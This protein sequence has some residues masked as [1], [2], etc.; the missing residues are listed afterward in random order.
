MRTTLLRFM[1]AF[2]GCLAA[3]ILSWAALG[4]GRAATAAPAAPAAVAATITQ[5]V[6]LFPT[7]DNT[8]YE[9]TLGKVS[10]GAGQ[11]LFAGKTDTGAI[12]RGLLAF[13]LSVIPPGATVLSATLTLTMS[14]TIGGESVV[15][16]H[17]V[18]AGWGEGASD[19]A[20]E[21]GAGATAEVGDAT[22]LHT[23]YDTDLWGQPGGDFEPVPSAATAVEGPGV[24]H[25]A[26]PGLSADVASWLAGPATHHGW[27]LLG[28]ETADRT[29]KRFDSREND[30]ANRPRLTITYSAVVERVLVPV[31]V[32]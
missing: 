3:L 28:D 8:L 16:L 5:T 18:T 17:A 30:P 29:A 21:E 4:G 27:A 24:Y 9:T 19:A 23:F 12:R 32:K 10:N 15:A 20:G 1:A 7:R 26:S 22:W 25:W 31:I 11:H 6:A 13:D 14:K 2:A